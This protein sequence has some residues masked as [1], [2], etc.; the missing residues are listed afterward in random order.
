MV[1]RTHQKQHAH[2]VAVVARHF[3]QT[4]PVKRDRDRADRILREHKAHEPRELLRVQLGTAQHLHKLVEHAAQNVPKL[5]QLLRPLR[6]AALPSVS[7]CRCSSSGS[8][9]SVR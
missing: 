6:F 5:R 8:A 2:G 4:H 1:V 3:S 9:I 7:V